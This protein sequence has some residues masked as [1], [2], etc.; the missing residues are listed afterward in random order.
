[1]QPTPSP[2]SP[3]PSSPLQQ[4]Q[5][6]AGDVVRALAKQLHRAATSDSLATALPVLRRILATHTLRGLTL[7]HLHRQRNIVQ[8]KHLLRTL[9]IEAGFASWEAYAKALQSMAVDHL[10]HL[11]VLRASA[12]Y[13]NH[14]FSTRAEAE[15]FAQGCG[16]RVVSVGTQAVVL[17]ATGH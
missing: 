2:S 16:G 12:G 10:D 17:L 6:K 3:V 8:R 5:Q 14:W 15:A 4:Q 7:P 13:P 9:A 1:M 11:D